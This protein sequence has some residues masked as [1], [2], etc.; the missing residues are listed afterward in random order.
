M[1]E[2]IVGHTGFFLGENNNKKIILLL[3]LYFTAISFF[4][5][6]S[7]YTFINDNDDLILWSLLVDGEPKTLIMSYPL[8]LLMTSLYDHFPH[9]QWY[10]LIVFFYISLISLLFSYYI[11]TLNDKYVK[12]LSILLATL[13][14]IHIWLQVSVTILTLLLVAVSIPLVRKHQVVFWILLLTASFLRTGIIISLLPLFA[15]AY[16][17]LYEK[18]YL[19]YKKAFI[20]LVLG[21]LTMFNYISMS[22]DKEYNEWRRYNAA[23]SYFVDYGGIDTK[24]ILSEG[25]K[26]ILYIWWAQD[27]V[28]VPT[29]KVIK[30]SGTL[31]NVI[32]ERLSEML[33]S[34]V[35]A[36]RFLYKTERNHKLLIFIILITL[37][38]IYKEQSNFYRAVYLLFMFGFFGLTL[39][40]DNDR[41]VF[42]II[43]LWSVLIFLKLLEK[44]EIV[45][46]KSFL[47]AAVLITAVNLPVERIQN[48]AINE[49]LRFEFVQLI[50]SYPMKYEV[51]S[52]FPRILKDVGVVFV[53]SHIFFEKYWIHIGR[54]RILLSA[55]IARHPYF[56]KTHNISFKDKKRKYENFYEF[57]MD[58]NT[59]FIGSKII[60]SKI[61]STILAMYDRKRP[62]P[63]GCHHSIKV[64]RETEHFSI[65]QLILNCTTGDS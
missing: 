65:V 64:L 5:I 44:K 23:R 28:L 41:G 49:K 25:E 60:S 55:W 3:F 22:F 53:Q 45:L 36:A 21:S 50:D 46:L 9:M 4:M 61:N 56:Y 14:L 30:A 20:I 19:T 15:I 1:E 6:V 29:E 47:F 34:P 38:I 12:A 51:S 42:P 17:L 16:F 62:H 8:S 37:Y 59:G 35:E 40:R 27:D 32:I 7:K 54:D 33:H 11:S 13:I 18:K 52:S 24:G 31:K 48:R 58:D 57:L 63:Q 10:S 43:V 39:I 26:S 2:R